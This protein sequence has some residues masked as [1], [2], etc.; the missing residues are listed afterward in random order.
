M[1]CRMGPQCQAFPPPVKL[2]SDPKNGVPQFLRRQSRKMV[3]CYIYT[4]IHIV[5]YVCMY[6]YIYMYRII[7]YICLC[8]HT[9]TEYFFGVKHDKQEPLVSSFFGFYR[10]S[11]VHVFCFLPL[12]ALAQSPPLTHGLWDWLC[13]GLV[14]MLIRVICWRL[15]YFANRKSTTCGIYI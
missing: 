4:Y 9:H 2:F 15:F 13:M 8:A 1:V 11:F 12:T 5:M 10:C 14:N 6:I 3:G 7:V